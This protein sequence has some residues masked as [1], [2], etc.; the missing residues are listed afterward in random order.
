MK[1]AENAKRE[2]LTVSVVS[3]PHAIGGGCGLSVKTNDGAAGKRLLY[4]GKY[5]GFSGMYTVNDR[6]I[7]NLVKK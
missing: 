7:V 4:L 6:G 1:F 3:T 2:G 5:T